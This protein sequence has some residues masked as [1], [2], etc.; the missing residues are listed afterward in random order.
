[1]VRR[2]V[3]VTHP[4]RIILFGSAAR[5]KMGADSDLGLLVVIPNGVHRRQTAGIPRCRPQG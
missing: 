3:E 2:I 4:L 1:M 5:G